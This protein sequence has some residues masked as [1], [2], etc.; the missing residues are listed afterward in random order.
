MHPPLWTELAAGANRTLS[1]EQLDRLSKYLDLLLEANRRMNL[2][3]IVDRDAAELQHVADALTL[4]KFIP[5]GARR[6]ADVGSGGGVPGVPLAVALPEVQFVLLESTRKKAVFLE[7]AARELALANVRVASMRAEDAGRD[8]AFRETFEVVTA[9]A[10]GA[11]NWIAEWCLP[12]LRKGGVLLAMK[13][14]KAAEELPLAEHAIKLL[15]GGSPDV[16]PAGLPGAG[17]HV[18]V[19][20]RKIA[21]TPPAYPRPATATRGKPL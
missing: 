4:L 14:P 6:I 18:I 9:R 10:V 15:G 8:A 17:G 5:P 21:K 3:R 16:R 11:M 7:E 12:L 19:A 20:I 13:G 2:T 1:E